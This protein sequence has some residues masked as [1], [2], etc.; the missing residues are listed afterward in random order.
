MRIRDIREEHIRDCERVWI[1]AAERL[2]SLRRQFCSGPCFLAFEELKK[3]FQGGQ[4]VIQLDLKSRHGHGA[5][6]PSLGLAAAFPTSR[7]AMV[8]GSAGEALI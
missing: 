3:E 6:E 8:Q 1:I 2:A 4:S 7:L 5:R